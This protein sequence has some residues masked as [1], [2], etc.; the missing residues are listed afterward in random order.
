MTALTAIS[1][2]EPRPVNLRRRPQESASSK[3]PRAARSTATRR[4]ARSCS[5]T[6]AD[7]GADSILSHALGNTDTARLPSTLRAGR[8][9][10]RIA[11]RTGEP[12]I[13]RNRMLAAKVSA[14]HA[15]LTHYFHA[16]PIKNQHCGSAILGSLSCAPGAISTVRDRQQRQ[17]R[18]GNAFLSRI[19]DVTRRCRSGGL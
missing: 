13:L 12:R 11:V 16:A 18:H 3:R 5:L 7:S 1:C 2:I 19:S 6:V 8:G 4:W 15:A 10:R 9:Q 17:E 14:V